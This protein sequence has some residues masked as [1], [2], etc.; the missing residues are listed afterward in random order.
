[1]EPFHAVSLVQ[2]VVRERV[3]VETNE[4]AIHDA[5]VA[6]QSRATAVLGGPASVA[7]SSSPQ[8]LV[9]P[10]TP[11]AGFLDQAT[12]AYLSQLGAATSLT[13][14]Q[15]G[16]PD[17]AKT[18]FSQ[19]NAATAAAQQMGSVQPATTWVP[20]RSPVPPA[21]SKESAA[22][23]LLDVTMSKQ[24]FDQTSGALKEASADIVMMQ[25]KL[26]REAE[27]ARKTEQR[28]EAVQQ[29][30]HETEDAAYSM[31][32]RIKVL[33]A[34]VDRHR[35]EEAMDL[36]L[37]NDLQA[38]LSKADAGFNEAQQRVAAA[39]AR[40]A[41]WQQAAKDSEARRVEAEARLAKK[42]QEEREHVM[43]EKASEERLAQ[44]LQ[45]S[46]QAVH[47]S[48]ELAQQGAASF[49]RAV[50]Q[51]QEAN[52]QVSKLRQ[53]LNGQ[54]ELAQEAWVAAQEQERRMNASAARRM[55]AERHLAD[56]LAALQGLEP[57]STLQTRHSDSLQLV[58]ASP[59]NSQATSWPVPEPLRFEANAPET[60]VGRSSPELTMPLMDS[61]PLPMPPLTPQPAPPVVDSRGVEQV[62][63]KRAGTLEGMLNQ[64]Y[65]LLSQRH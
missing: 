13:Q 36:Q 12:Q 42:T 37:R 31:E 4:E 52:T 33:E 27:A 41:Q 18:Y 54:K 21:A 48:H 10:Q 26:D 62:D 60:L 57:V 47:A 30:L 53:E 35:T 14:Q 64:L 40:R 43:S 2:K 49:T 11:Y 61:V 15:A 29:R 58:P 65:I 3:A 44:Y 59:V 38:K 25:G 8:T 16:L 28:Y 63:T 17:Q 32:K 5:T 56:S 23:S 39:E 45:E 34:E 9:A 46:S 6:S 20:A 24:D 50:A 1:M 55:A 51:L 22:P 7:P 19:L